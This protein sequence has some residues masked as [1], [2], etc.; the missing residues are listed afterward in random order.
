MENSY[1]T[2]EVAGTTSSTK[3]PIVGQTYAEGNNTT[4]AEML[5]CYYTNTPVNATNSDGEQKT[6][7]EMKSPGMLQLMNAEKD[8]FV[9]AYGDFI[10]TN[11]ELSDYSLVT[12]AISKIPSDLSLFTDATTSELS[13]KQ[14]AVIKNRLRADQAIVNGYATDIENAVKSLKIKE[15]T[16]TSDDNSTSRVKDNNIPKTGDNS[17]ILPFAILAISSAGTL[18][19]IGRKKDLPNSMMHILSVLNTQFIFLSIFHSIEIQISRLPHPSL[20][21]ILF[22][23]QII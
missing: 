9:L 6:N 7:E 19:F 18:V 16:S 12:N 8:V 15:S 13:S 22:L 10:V 2:G 4:K 21:Q 23:S 5:N 11:I 14:S 20:K 17:T 3:G 1:S